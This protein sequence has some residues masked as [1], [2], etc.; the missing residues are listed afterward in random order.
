V[1][2]SED[3]ENRLLELLTERTA[4]RLT[5]NEKDELANLLAAHPSW[6]EDDL[7]RAAAAVAIAFT[8][9]PP[10]LPERLRERIREDAERHLDATKVLPRSDTVRVPPPIEEKT[11]DTLKRPIFLP[12][13]LK[14][15]A[16]RSVPVD[17]WR[18]RAA[19][20][21]AASIGAVVTGSIAWLTGW[22]PGPRS[23][24]VRSPKDARTELLAAAKD[25]I[26][27][28]WSPGPDELG[29]TVTGDV[30]WSEARQA[31]FMRFRGLAAQAPTEKQYQLWIFDRH[32]DERYPVDG[33]VFDIAASA[34]EV[35]VAIQPKIHVA[36]ATLFAITLEKAGGVVVSSREH[37]VVVAKV[38]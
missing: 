10:A 18:R 24:P 25:A 16:Q 9:D 11:S 23:N 32:R 6:A 20:A 15:A 34:D 17:L 22:R 29:R 4:R 28:A 31:G 14:A 35:I 5:D 30:V 2:A 7:E 3:T 19:L 21:A 27:L 37:L 13:E 33:G 36:N 8:K 1:S 12:P 38:V 26:T